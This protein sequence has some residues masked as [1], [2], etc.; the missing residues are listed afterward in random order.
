MLKAWTPF[1]DSEVDDSLSLHYEG[2]DVGA[3]YACTFLATAAIS[4]GYEN[5]LFDMNVV[6][7]T[8][9]YTTIARHK[10]LLR[11]DSVYV[12]SRKVE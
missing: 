11:G 3:D 4:Q 10:Q 5:S 2:E 8:R 7:F 12:Q 1:P 6:Y 9:I